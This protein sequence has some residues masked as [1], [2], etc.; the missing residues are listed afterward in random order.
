MPNSISTHVS[1]AVGV[2]LSVLAVI[3]PGFAVSSTV[4]ELTVSIGIGGAL[5][6]QLAHVNLK[7]KALAAYTQV[8]LYVK[9]IESKLPAAVQADVNT[10]ADELVQNVKAAVDSGDASAVAKTLADVPEAPIA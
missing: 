8:Q 5:L 2:I 4:K 1:S 10:V 9:S 7:A 3:H 6:L